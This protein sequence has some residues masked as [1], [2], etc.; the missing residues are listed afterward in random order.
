MK[1]GQRITD[2]ASGQ[3]GMVVAE[4]QTH[5]RVRLS[6]GKCVNVPKSA[7]KL[8]RERARRLA[9]KR[10]NKAAREKRAVAARAKEA[11]N[12]EAALERSRSAWIGPDAELSRLARMNG[13]TY[14]EALSARKG[15]L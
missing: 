14:Q 10:R 5:Y 15:E 3:K 9:D 2:P 13:L 8:R 7:E 6:I 1:L 11:A 12:R 4:F